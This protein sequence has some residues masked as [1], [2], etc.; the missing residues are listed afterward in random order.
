M[1][2]LTINA[3]ASKFVRHRGSKASCD[4]SEAKYLVV[5]L[6]RAQ[7]DGQR[8]LGKNKRKSHDPPAGSETSHFGDM[9]VFVFF[10]L[11]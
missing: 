4:R 10:Q 9:R 3:L 8:T 11:V 2:V 7:K 1:H 5:K 6:C